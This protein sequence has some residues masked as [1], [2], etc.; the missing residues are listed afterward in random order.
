MFRPVVFVFVSLHLGSSFGTYTKKY[1]PPS[2]HPD[3][4]LQAGSQHDSDLDDNSK[5]QLQAY[6]NTISPPCQSGASEVQ[7]PPLD[8]QPLIVS[9]PSANR[10]NLVFFSDGYTQTEHTKFLSDALRLAEDVSKNE[11]FNT[12]QPLL[13]FWAAFTPS[14]HSGLGVDKPNDTPFGLYRIGSELRGVYVGHQKTG[15]AACDSLGSQCDVP[16]FL[17]NDPRYGG[18]GGDLVTITSSTLNG[19][20][21]LRHELGHNLIGVGEEYDGGDHYFGHNAAHDA[22]DIPWNHWLSNSTQKDKQGNPRVERAIMALQVYPW[23]L[24]NMSSPWSASFSSSGSYHRYSVQFSLS[25]IPQKEDLRVTLD[26][27]DLKWTPRGGVGDDRWFYEFVVDSSL[28]NGQHEIKF[29]L[30]NKGIEGSA[31]LCSTEILEYGKE[32]EFI[33]KPGFYSLYPTFSSTNKTSYR[34]TNADCLMRAVTKPNFCSICLETLW[35]NLL[36]GI[37]LIDDVKEKCSAGSSASPSAKVL[38]VNLIP[39]AHLRQDFSISEEAYSIIWRKDGQ[40]LNQYTNQTK[41]KLD[42]A[43]TT[44]VYQ[45]EVEYA[46]PEI[47]ISSQYLKATRKHIVKSDCT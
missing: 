36:R 33:A 46:T 17:G 12:V 13:N 14:N 37:S 25:G 16:I 35:I 3:C 45:V 4:K 1:Q 43:Q 23:T 8:I 39:L 28:P 5:S 27:Q 29:E 2:H 30:L 44:G 20:L 40:L 47:R 32:E 15:R 38:E 10:N 24:L 7:I 18:I 21:V 19:P 42:G 34:P 6:L 41:I 31:Q 11:T 22:Q 26:G 9:G